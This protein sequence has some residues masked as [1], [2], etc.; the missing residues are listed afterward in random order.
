MRQVRCGQFALQCN[1]PSSF[2][3]GPYPQIAWLSEE[4]LGWAALYQPEKGNKADESICLLEIRTLSEVNIIE[5]ELFPGFT[6]LVDYPIL[7]H[8]V[9]PETSQFTNLAQ[10]GSVNLSAPALFLV[11]FSFTHVSSLTPCKS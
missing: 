9:F 8:S 10:T 2:D 6:Y 3:V 11:V 1:Y 7:P 5:D 4:D